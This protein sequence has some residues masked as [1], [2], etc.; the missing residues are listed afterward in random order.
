MQQEQQNKAGR[1]KLLCGHLF[2][3]RKTSIASHITWLLSP[4]LS[5]LTMAKI[6]E[7]RLEAVTAYRMQLLS[8]GETQQNY[9]FA[10]QVAKNG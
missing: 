6:R 9:N 8:C 4:A 2:V 3:T 1:D 5:S 10:L 7:K